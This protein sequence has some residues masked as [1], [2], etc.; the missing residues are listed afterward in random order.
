MW[1]YISC[2]QR[3]LQFDN[4]LLEETHHDLFKLREVRKYD[5]QEN[6]HDTQF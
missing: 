6:M 1:N 4:T 5:R 2:L 3:N